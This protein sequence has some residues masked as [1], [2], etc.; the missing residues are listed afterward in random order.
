ML[1]FHTTSVVVLL[2]AATASAQDA[3]PTVADSAGEASTEAKT[4]AAK[5]VEHDLEIYNEY[6]E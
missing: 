4:D 2:C 1:R 6:F 3:P 5:K